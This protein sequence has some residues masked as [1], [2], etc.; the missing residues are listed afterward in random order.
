MERPKLM[1]TCNE[2]LK[3]IHGIKNYTYITSKNIARAWNRTDFFGLIITGEQ[4]IGKSTYAI[5]VMLELYN[6]AWRIVRD[7]IFFALDELVEFLYKL[8]ETN[9]RALCIL[10]DDAGVHGHKYLY[11]DDRKYVELLSGLADTVRTSVAGWLITT[12]T[13]SN[14]VI[15]IRESPGFRIGQ[16]RKFDSET[17]NRYIKV[18]KKYE[19]P[20]WKYWRRVYIDKF[21]AHLPDEIYMEYIEM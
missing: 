4:G 9:D 20:T 6:N 21:T 13:H 14:I 11:Y 1:K 7:R 17:T 10:W 15:S 18:Y 8:H 3:H 16:V 2:E 12:P 5:K 19:T